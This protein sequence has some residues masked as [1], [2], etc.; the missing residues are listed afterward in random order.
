MEEIV[1]NPI[2]ATKIGAE[3]KKTALKYFNVKHYLNLILD[4]L[5]LEN[6]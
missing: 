6:C 2:K 3:A 1:N 5:K 4:N